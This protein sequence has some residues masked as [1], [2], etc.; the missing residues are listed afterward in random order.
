MPIGE[1]IDSN[2][3]TGPTTIFRENQT[4]MA[5]VTSDI[6][7]RDL[8]SVI[9]DIEAGIEDLII[10]EGY[11]IEFGG[12]TQDMQDSFKSL[13]LALIL[14]LFFVYMIMAAQFESLINPLVI[15]FTL[16]LTF[17]G[18]VFALVIS[19][20]SLSVPA[21]IG[22]IMLAGIAVNNGIVLVDYINLLR[23]KGM[24]RKEAVIETGVTRIRPVLM[25]TITTVMG[26]LPLALGLGEG[27]ETQA[28]MATVV[29]GGL[30]FSA[31]VTLVLIPV[32]YTL[33]DDASTKVKDWFETL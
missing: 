5:F 13:A 32:M 17:I 10:P 24:G 11:E 4:R 25:T 28:P 2:L 6:V 9:A 12:E 29:V 33:L 1:L 21:L 26:L 15:M 3:G 18:I 23:S 22:V 14:A 27:A 7:G 30:T 16:P 20:R 31:I 19:G 8:G